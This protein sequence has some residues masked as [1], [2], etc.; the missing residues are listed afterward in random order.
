MLISAEA[1]TQ[2]GVDGPAAG[3]EPRHDAAGDHGKAHVWNSFE[4]GS[5]EVTEAGNSRMV[6]VSN[7]D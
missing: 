3:T 7:R 6:A 5:S 4:C 2:R 1:S